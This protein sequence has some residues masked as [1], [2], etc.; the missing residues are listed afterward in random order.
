M[1]QMCHKLQLHEWLAAEFHFY[2]KM[3]NSTAACIA[4]NKKCFLSLCIVFSILKT[5]MDGEFF[6]SV[7]WGIWCLRQSIMA[8]LRK[9][10]NTDHFENKV[11]IL[12]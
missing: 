10:T 6:K 2:L 9:K 11:E 8:T 1:M 5:C 3:H 12:F 7:V 4:Y